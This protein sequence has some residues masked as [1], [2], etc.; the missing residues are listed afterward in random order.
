MFRTDFR[1]FFFGLEW[2]FY[3]ALWCEMIEKWTQLHDV[4]SQTQLVFAAHV[5]WCFC[6]TYNSQT[7]STSFEDI[8]FALTFKKNHFFALHLWLLNVH[9]RFYVTNQNCYDLYCWINRYQYVHRSPP[10]VTPGGGVEG[11]RRRLDF[12]DAACHERYDISEQISEFFSQKSL[13]V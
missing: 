4:P 8:W 2:S 7:T 10:V 1:V 13:L 6:K 12:P 11:R 3:S 5:L 9:H